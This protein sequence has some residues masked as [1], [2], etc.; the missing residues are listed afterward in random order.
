MAEDFE[1]GLGGVVDEDEG[2]AVVVEE[3]AG[4]DVLLVAAIVGE[5]DGA[6]VEDMDEAR[7]AAAMLDVGPAGFAGRGHVEGVAGRYEVAL[8]FGEAVAG[9]AGLLGTSVGST[10]AVEGLLLFDERR[11]GYLGEALTHLEPWQRG[12]DEPQ[13]TGVFS[14]LIRRECVG[15]GI[16]EYD[17]VVP[18]STVLVCLVFAE[19]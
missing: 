1:A 18:Q 16:R 8:G 15:C 6:V 14:T 12:G 2:Y 3:V 4:G 7:R 13:Y 11:E 9:R 17:S 10:A 19:M 5:G